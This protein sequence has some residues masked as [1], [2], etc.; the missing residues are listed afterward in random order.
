MTHD[1]IIELFGTSGIFSSSVNYFR[2]NTLA[3]RMNHMRQKSL[4]V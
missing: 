1:V 2:D 4:V 3:I